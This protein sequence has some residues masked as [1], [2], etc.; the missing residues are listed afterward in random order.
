MKALMPP[1][2]PYGSRELRQPNEYG[3]KTGLERIAAL[4]VAAVMALAITT[5]CSA[6]TD[7]ICGNDFLEHQSEGDNDRGADCG[8][9]SSTWL[10]DYRTPGHWIPDEV[11]PMKTILVNMVVCRDAQGGDGWQDTPAMIADFEELIAQVNLN[12]A[13]PGTM[14]WPMTCPPSIPYLA[15]SRIRF[16]FNHAYFLDNDAFNNYNS[17]A[18]PS[19]ILDYLWAN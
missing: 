11:T 17:L 4:S 9:S 13:D 19:A 1:P 7:W 3:L 6:Q 16:K 12:Y 15:D 18:S 10:N 14:G 2:P 5:T 8:N